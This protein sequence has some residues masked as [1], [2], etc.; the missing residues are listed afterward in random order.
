[1]LAIMAQFGGKAVSDDGQRCLLDQP[2]NIAALEFCASLI[3][4][5]YAPRPENFD[6]WIG[7][8]QG[9][10]ALAFDGIYLLSDLEKQPELD[11]GG[12]PLPVLGKEPATWADSHG[13]CLSPGM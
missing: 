7:F 10:V 9:R 2:A 12:A 4:D 8:R 3:R 6:A 13:L 11:F 1:A 5:G